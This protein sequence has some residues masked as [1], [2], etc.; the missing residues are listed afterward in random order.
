MA[1]RKKEGAR[2]TVVLFVDSK[3]D[4]PS[5]LA[6]HYATQLYPGIYDV[7]SAGPEKDI[8]DCDLLS[9]MYCQGEDLR[10]LVSKDF[11][12]E[13]RL[14]QGECPYDYVIY[15]QKAV[16]D[17][18]SGK[19]P[20]KGRQI[21]AHMGTREE[22]DCTDDAELAQCLLAMA[23]RVRKWVQENMDDPEKLKALVSA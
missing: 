12:D 1:I 20:W 16:F 10:D 15:L 19:S 7:Y 21:L 13:K 5:Q 8:V 23:D 14:P 4:L 22:F 18:Y 6:E 11:F 9:V 17:K 3:N 2:K